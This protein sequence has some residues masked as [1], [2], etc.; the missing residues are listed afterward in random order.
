MRAAQLFCIF[1]SAFLPFSPSAYADPAKPRITPPYSM[2]EIYVR[3]EALKTILLQKFPDDTVAMLELS[4]KAAEFRGYVAGTIDQ[5]EIDDPV[6]VEC[7]RRH[8]LQAIAGRTAAVL[9][10]IP[11]DRSKAAGLGVLLAIH[12]AC[13]DL[14]K[15]PI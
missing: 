1:A 9:T 12:Y 14:K 6:L 13:N 10:S 3:A 11:L 7:T 4:N 2:E 15:K 5:Q 8:T